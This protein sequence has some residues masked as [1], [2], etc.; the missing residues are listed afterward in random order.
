MPKCRENLR[1]RRRHHLRERRRLYFHLKAVVPLDGRSR[2]Y[3]EAYDIRVKRGRASYKVRPTNQ[4]TL[5]MRQL[6]KMCEGVTVN[7]AAILPHKE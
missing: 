3:Y 4:Y 7:L 6:A 2:P 5:L 1:Y